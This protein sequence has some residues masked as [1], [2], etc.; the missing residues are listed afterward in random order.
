MN[1]KKK[2]AWNQNLPLGSLP[3]TETV[4][5]RSKRS[6]E[7]SVFEVSGGK[8]RSL[9]QS[10]RGSTNDKKEDIDYLITIH[11]SSNETEKVGF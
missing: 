8:S 7:S 6:E 10:S 2:R 9:L 1:W 4:A 3:W 11:I 5:T